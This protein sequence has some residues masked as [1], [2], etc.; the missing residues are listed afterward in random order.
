MAIAASRATGDRSEEWDGLM[1]LGS[2]WLS[3]DYKEAGAYFQDALTLARTLGDPRRIAH[4]LNRVGNWQL[5]TGQQPEALLRHNEALAIFQDVGDV[6]G[7]AATLDL[8]G[9]TSY[10]LVKPH[11]EMVYHRE[12]VRL[13]RELGNR[14]GAI[15]GL[16]LLAASSSSYEW[17]APPTDEA[18]LNASIAAGEEALAECQTIEWSAGEAFAC[19]TLAMTYG[20]NGHYDRAFALTHD[21]LQIAKEIQHDQWQA[22]MLRVLGY[23]YLDLLMPEQA[24]LYLVEGMALAKKI[25]SDFW[26]VSLSSALASALVALGDVNAAVGLLEPLDERRP[27]VLT[28]WHSG[29]SEVEVALAR[30][31]YERVVRMT[32]LL[33]AAAWPDGRPSRFTLHRVEALL[34][35]KRPEEAAQ[36]IEYVLSHAD[37]LPLAMRWRGEVLHGRVLTAHGQRAEAT[38]GVS[39]RARN[40]RDAGSIDQRCRPSPDIHEPGDGNAT[41]IETGS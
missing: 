11:Q 21:G 17:P 40:Y 15:A 10:H 41:P 30:R 18:E 16:T 2:L 5:N 13:F 3:R 24:R 28:A 6:E 14:Q 1:A 25:G 29:Y 37:R 31:E 8:L 4:S 32:A 36:L 12:A 19:N 23:L 33:G 22:C 9:M 34:G 39:N 20:W 38:Q 35:L 26:T 7:T 27:L